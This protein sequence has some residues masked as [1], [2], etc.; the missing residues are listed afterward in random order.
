MKHKVFIVIGILIHILIIAQSLLP[1]SLSSSQSGLIVDVLHPLVLNMGI[2]IDVVTFSFIVRK[3]AHFTEF[4][5]L[6]VFWYLVYMKYFSKLKLIFAVLIHGL[7]TAII[8]ETMQLFIDGRSGEVRDVLIDF[9]GVLLAAIVMHYVI[10]R[11][12]RIDYENS[13]KNT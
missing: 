8:D 11:R 12:K 6:A 2:Q 1:G 7:I 9:M 3:L 4:F 10:F 5:V 13:Q